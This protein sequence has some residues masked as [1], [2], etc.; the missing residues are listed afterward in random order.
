MGDHPL[1]ADVHAVDRIGV[2]QILAIELIDGLLLHER[3]D[4]DR[5]GCVA[6]R[7]VDSGVERAGGKRI[8]CVVVIVQARC[9]VA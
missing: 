3:Q 9:L 7:A 2:E 6:G 8:L 1:L 4:L 5:P